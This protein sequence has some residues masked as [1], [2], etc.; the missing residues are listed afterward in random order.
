M[1]S[2]SG[3]PAGH[4][5]TELSAEL[6]GELRALAAGFFRREK[7][8]H[9][10]Q[11]TALVHEAWVR[12][13]EGREPKWGDRGHFLATVAQVMRRLLVDHARRRSAVRHGGEVRRVSLES[14]ALPSPDGVADLV[15]LDELL[16]R[17]AEIDPDRGRLAVQKVFAG[18]TNA[19]VAALEG[20]CERT[21]ERRWRATRAWLAAEWTGGRQD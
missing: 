5:L 20:V 21:V 4:S 13:A 15:E 10:L 1:G 12:L 8:G 11:P 7:P 3:A 14:A 6:H 2:H 16:E 17:L 19:E 18:M 9:T